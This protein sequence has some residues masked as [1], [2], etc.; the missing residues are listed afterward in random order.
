MRGKYFAVSLL[1]MISLVSFIS[2]PW[3]DSARADTNQ[4]NIS[5]PLELSVGGAWHES[6][7]IRD[8]W[9]FDGD[10]YYDGEDGE[11][12]ELS[13]KFENVNAIDDYSLSLNVAEVEPELFCME[14]GDN[15]ILYLPGI[16]K[17]KLPESDGL[18]P[19][20]EIIYEMGNVSNTY[21]MFNATR[22][23]VLACYYDGIFSDEEYLT[24]E[25]VLTATIANCTGAVSLRS[26]P[27]TASKAITTILFGE[28]VEVYAGS[29]ISDG[30]KTFMKVS[31][32]GNEGYV[33]AKYL[34]YEED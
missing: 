11:W 12:G 27:S 34:D 13:G 21:I 26:E 19:Y 20:D 6:I 1:L 16:E 3:I 18:E 31:F 17:E 8:N 33:L 22:G 5:F 23:F 15:C 2:M 4:Y 30:W 32:R 14:P 9:K 29:S 10:Y 25:T 28:S 7:S 24:E